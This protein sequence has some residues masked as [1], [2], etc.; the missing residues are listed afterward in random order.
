M[1]G[2]PRAGSNP[3]ADGIFGTFQRFNVNIK[4]CV[5]GSNPVSVLVPIS[6]VVEQSSTNKKVP[7]LARLA[8]LDSAPDF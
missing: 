2:I 8:Q 5:T 6:S 7:S 4:R 1:L 3:A